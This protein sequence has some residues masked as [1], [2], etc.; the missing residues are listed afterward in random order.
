MSSPPELPVAASW[1]L[2]PAPQ[3]MWRA[4]SSLI[5]LVWPLAC[6][7]IPLPPVTRSFGCWSV[8]PLRLAGSKPETLPTDGFGPGGAGLDRVEGFLT[9][10]IYSIARARAESRAGEASSL[11][12]DCRTFR[13]ALC[14]FFCRKVCPSSFN[15]SKCSL[16]ACTGKGERRSSP[17]LVLQNEKQMHFEPNPDGTTWTK[18]L[19][20]VFASLKAYCLVLT[21][22]FN[23]SLGVWPYS[24]LLFILACSPEVPYPPF[25]LRSQ[26]V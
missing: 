7:P 9:D 6:L 2:I 24:L 5:T 17:A 13:V 4:A 23:A 12:L 14:R 8:M 10:L 20:L 19:Q 15:F 18:L 3:A 11:G 1:S 16:F 26:A 25:C 22:F 21:M